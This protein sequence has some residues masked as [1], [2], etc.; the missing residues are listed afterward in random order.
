V[1]R[2]IG[3]ESHLTLV[4]VAGLTKQPD[5]YHAGTAYEGETGQPLAALANL[6]ERLVTHRQL[7]RWQSQ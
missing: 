7:G 6:S 2:Q 3:K 4:G 1:P 5:K